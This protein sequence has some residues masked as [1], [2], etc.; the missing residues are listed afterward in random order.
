MQKLKKIIQDAVFITFC[1]TQ[2]PRR[3]HAL[4]GD[5]PCADF[6]TL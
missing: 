5:T 1:G 4:W 3:P 6:L 2:A